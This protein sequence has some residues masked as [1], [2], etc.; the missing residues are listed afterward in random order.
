M[1][2]VF[3]G[4]F[5]PQNFDDLFRGEIRRGDWLVSDDIPTIMCV[6][7]TDIPSRV[8][9]RLGAIPPATCF[10]P[11]HEVVYDCGFITVIVP[12]KTCLSPRLVSVNV[13]RCDPLGNIDRSWARKM[14]NGEVAQ[15]SQR[16]WRTTFMA[17][18]GM[19]LQSL[20]SSAAGYPAASPGPSAAE[21]AAANAAYAAA[22]AAASDHAETMD[23]V[24]TDVAWLLL[25]PRPPL[26]HGSQSSSS[27]GRGAVRNMMPNPSGV[28]PK[29]LLYTAPEPANARPPP[30]STEVCHNCLLAFD[31]VGRQQ[32]YYDCMSH[33]ICLACIVESWPHIKAS[34]K[35]TGCPIC[36]LPV[37]FFISNQEHA[38]AARVPRDESILID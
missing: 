16:G 5:G 12:S 36:K 11:V 24:G 4:F 2:E 8:G 19:A 23:R 17:P 14:E 6:E 32:Q 22:N 9:F 33:A 34:A 3:R 29:G 37:P 27:P 7:Y 21:Y 13:G 38:Y 25:Q 1:D 20:V 10:G 28:W 35:R 30:E 18:P 26:G 31:G 15:W